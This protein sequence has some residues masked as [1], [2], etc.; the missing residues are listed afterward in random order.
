VCALLEAG[1]LMFNGDGAIYPRLDLE[2]SRGHGHT[3]DLGI[4]ALTL[5]QPW[6]SLIAL[7]AKQIE[8]RSWRTAYRGPVAIHAAVGMPPIRRGERMTLGDWEVERDSARS[9]LLRGPISHPYRLPL[10]AVVAVA[11][12]VDI[13]PT[14]ECVPGADES[15]GD[16]S[17]GRYAW[18]LSSVSP[19]RRAVPA[20]GALSL[21]PWELPAEINAQ[22][23]YP[24]RAEPVSVPPGALF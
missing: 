1:P 21:W 16:Y 4:K 11:Y 10:G 15:Y 20:K 7:G 14:S 24:V 3:G 8:T 22:L 13:L 19:I 2:E 17:A 23:R 5:T 12:L 9:L 18:C 6:A